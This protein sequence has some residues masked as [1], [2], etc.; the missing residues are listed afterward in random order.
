M[1]LIDTQGNLEIEISPVAKEFDGIVVLERRGGG[2]LPLSIGLC[3]GH[4][5][6]SVIHMNIV[7]AGIFLNQFSA[8]YSKAMEV[9]RAGGEN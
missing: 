2:D 9:F 1:K 5:L 6:Y 3:D 7:T 8:H 4:V